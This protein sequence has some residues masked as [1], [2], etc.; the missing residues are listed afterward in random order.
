VASH[1]GATGAKASHVFKGCNL[2][3]VA[4]I[5]GPLSQNRDSILNEHKAIIEAN[6]GR[7]VFSG[8]AFGMLGRAVRKRLGAV[9]ADEI[10]AHVLRLFAPGVKV[11]C[12]ISCMAADA[13]LIEVGEETLAIAGTSEGADTAVIL[14]PANTESFFDTR[15]REIICKPREWAPYD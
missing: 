15:I 9:Q 5:A 10:I 8:H 3:V 14:K 6:G 11:A 13:G 12:E 4:G 1:S 2:V 7:I